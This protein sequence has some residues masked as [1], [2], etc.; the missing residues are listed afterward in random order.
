M[1]KALAENAG[2]PAIVPIAKE[3][4]RSNYVGVSLQTGAVVA[5]GVDEPTVVE[6]F[7]SV[8]AFVEWLA[9]C[10]EAGKLRFIEGGGDAPSYLVHRQ[11]RLPNAVLRG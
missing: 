6:L 2:P 7:P 11:G 4:L 10:A 9:N 3:P 5:T 8:T 1:E